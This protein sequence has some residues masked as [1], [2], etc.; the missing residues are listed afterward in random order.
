MVK[1]T[2]YNRL[3]KHGKPI[4][5]L[6]KVLSGEDKNEVIRKTKAYNARWNKIPKEKKEG[7]FA[8]LEIVRVSKPRKKPTKRTVAFGLPLP[9]RR[10]WF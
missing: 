2:S 5:G 7:N 9:K 4:T 8:K 3:Y 1:Y 6:Y 10:S